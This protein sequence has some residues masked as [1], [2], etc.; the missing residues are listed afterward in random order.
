M[1]SHSDNTLF[2]KKAT[3]CIAMIFVYVDDIVVTGD[4]LSSIDEQINGWG[5][6]KKTFEIK[7]FCPLYLTLFGMFDIGLS[8]ESR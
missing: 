3:T 5:H 7:D 2:I 8:W 1:K 6:L 4:D